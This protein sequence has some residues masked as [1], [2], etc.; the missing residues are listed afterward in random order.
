MIANYNLNGDPNE[1]SVSL[2]SYDD[3]GRRIAAASATGIDSEESET[4]ATY[5][6][7][8]FQVIGEYD[9]NGELVRRFVYGSGIDEVVAMYE[10]PAGEYFDYSDFLPIAASRLCTSQDAAMTTIMTT[11]LCRTCRIPLMDVIC[12][13]Y[14]I[15]EL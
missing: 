9:G 12:L 4:L 13:T 5:L 2:Y 6:Y 10:V 15:D 7:D 14:N 8:G 3:F 1:V 11:Y